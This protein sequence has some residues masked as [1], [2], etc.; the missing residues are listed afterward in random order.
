MKSSSHLIGYFKP[1]IVFEPTPQSCHPAE[2]SA[3]E[4]ILKDIEVLSPNHEE[5]LSLYG[6]DEPLPLHSKEFKI[7]IEEIMRYILD[8]G[9]G[10]NGEGIVVVRCNKLGSVVGTRKQGIR[11]VPAYW[12]GEDE[13]RV[14]D[15]TGGKYHYLLP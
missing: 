14:K 8:I 6:K 7:E 9:I 13:K 12:E 2:R 3:L 10:E 15:V 1:K 11:W 4:S 5:L